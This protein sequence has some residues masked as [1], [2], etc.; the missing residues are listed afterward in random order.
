MT[1]TTTPAVNTMK[2]DLLRVAKEIFRQKNKVNDSLDLDEFVMDCYVKCSS[3]SYGPKIEKKLI[4][5]FGFKK[6]KKNLGQGDLEIVENT[7]FSLYPNFKIGEKMEL[8][9]SFLT[10]ETACYNFIQ[11]RPYEVFDYYL[12]LTID[13]EDDFKIN[14]Y[15]LNKKDVVSKN[16]KLNAIHGTKESVSQNVN[17]EYKLNVKKNSNHHNKLIE[18]NLIK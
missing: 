13:C 9:V 17:I 2:D 5:K 1:K 7:K 10:S 6:V 4:K 18:L 3:Q 14:W 15:L 16:F 12:F 11:L 8:K